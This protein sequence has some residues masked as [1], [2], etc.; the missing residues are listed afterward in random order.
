[1]ITLLCAV[2]A[3]GAAAA[4]PEVSGVIFGD[5]YWFVSHHEKS[6]QDRTGFWFRR[7][8]LTVDHEMEPGIDARVR[9]ELNDPG[10][11][12]T[13]SRLQPY[14]KEAN[15]R[16]ALGRSRLEVGLFNTPTWYESEKLWGYRHVEKTPLDFQR[17]G[18]RVDTGIGVHGTLGP[19]NNT[20]YRIMLANGSGTETESNRGKKVMGAIGEQ[21]SS[22]ILA[23]IYLDYED[24]DG[25]TDRT[26]LQGLMGRSTESSRWGALFAR[27]IRE[28]PG[29]DLDLDVLSVFAA[30]QVRPT[31]WLIGRYDRTF[32]A[33]PEAD[34]IAYFVLSPDA[35]QNFFLVGADFGLRGGIH[36]IPNIEAVVYSDADGP[37]PDD[38]VI[39]RL[40][41]S[42]SWP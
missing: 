25:E 31:V 39:A 26:T 22:G 20:L 5:A 17:M 37:T 41:F 38:V 40:T 23:E 12:V 4:E 19:D 7:V 36:V 33:N 3:A 21:F 32:D 16:W 2:S 35:D 30:R 24:R 8:Y 34:R 18:T 1:M 6:I 14:L 9:F 15:V 42:A 13:R 11:F 10:D 28:Q 29:E 27:Q